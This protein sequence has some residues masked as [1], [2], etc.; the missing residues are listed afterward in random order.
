MSDRKK[1]VALETS[2][3]IER[4]I[5][6]IVFVVAAFFLTAEPFFLL[7]EEAEI[8][9]EY[10]LYGL[11]LIGSAAILC[12][13][14]RY[15]Y[16][17]FM[18]FEFENSDEY[19]KELNRI[20][21][22]RVEKLFTLFIKLFNIFG[23]LLVIISLCIIGYQGYSFLKSGV[24]SG[25]P[26]E[27]VVNYMPDDLASWY[28]QPKSWL[29]VQKIVSYVFAF[30]PLSLLLFLAGCYCATAYKKNHA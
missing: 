14:V 23:V 4:S 8:W 22:K 15:T 9:Y 24:W 28:Y 11:M 29:G 20:L 6:G 7:I 19:Q 18:G 30:V 21:A 12:W 1:K 16:R 25:I 5:V 10:V 13:C 17:G 27:L 26:L 3:R 2:D